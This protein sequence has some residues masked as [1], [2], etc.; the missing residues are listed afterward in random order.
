MNIS[1]TKNKP[2]YVCDKCRE[3]I[4]GYHKNSKRHVVPNKYYK[5]DKYGYPKKDFDL[6]NSCEKKFRK[7]LSE[8]EIP[9]IEDVKENFP[10]WE[11]N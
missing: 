3:E 1:K 7:W 5:A 2:K 9:R 10:R 11:G 8:K 4:I 6:C